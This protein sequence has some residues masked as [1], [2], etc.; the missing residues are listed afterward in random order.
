MINQTSSQ[1]GARP[2]TGFM[3]KRNDILISGFDVWKVIDVQPDYV[4][5]LLQSD[6]NG[7]VDQEEDNIGEFILR[8]D[9]DEG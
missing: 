3:L 6:I 4:V 5:A 7:L 1:P 8:S 2:G 9:I